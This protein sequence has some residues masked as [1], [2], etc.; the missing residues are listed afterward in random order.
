M[1]R[2]RPCGDGMVAL[3]E[4]SPGHSAAAVP[5][6]LLGSRYS[7]G[8]VETRAIEP[9][10]GA[11]RDSGW[12]ITGRGSVGPRKGLGL[13]NK[14]S[15]HTKTQVIVHLYRNY[16]H[17][18]HCHGSPI[19]LLSCSIIVPRWLRRDPSAKGPRVSPKKSYVLQ[20]VVV[21]YWH[22]YSELFTQL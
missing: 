15:T 20:T 18:G 14:H 11:A 6:G 21:Y 4:S 2:Q 5:V 7:M 19:T 10:Y 16:P 9:Q 12:G 17:R 22:L 8:P 1:S 13:E 3:H